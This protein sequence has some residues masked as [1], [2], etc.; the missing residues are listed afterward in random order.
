MDDIREKVYLLELNL[1]GKM[2]AT[3]VRGS[4]YCCKLALSQLVPLWKEDQKEG[5]QT[6]FAWYAFLDLPKHQ[7]LYFQ[8]ALQKSL[9]LYALL[10]IVQW[11]I[12]T[13]QKNLT[14]S[15]QKWLNITT[16]RKQTTLHSDLFGI[17]VFLTTFP[18]HSCVLQLIPPN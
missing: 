18:F 10:I 13:T 15:P 4:L 12:I 5:P 8:R 1:G 3:H 11:C 16:A 2:Q 9:Q 17:A 14:S 6:I 7:E